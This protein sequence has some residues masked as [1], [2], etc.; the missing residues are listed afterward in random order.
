[1]A[2]ATQALT[3][4]GDGNPS[5]R[6]GRIGEILTEYVGEGALRQLGLI[7]GLAAS[8]AAGIGLYQWAQEPMYRSLFAGLP[9]EDA[10][11]VAESL[12]AAGI[13]HHI[14]QVSGAIQ[15][16][17]AMLHDAR[18]K[19]AAEGLPN[20]GGVGFESL[21]Q[22]PGF[23][24]SHF[25]ETARFHRAL[26]TELG[27]TIASLRAVQSARVHLAIP[28]RSAFLRDQREPRAS[29]TVSLYSGRSL[30]DGQVTAIANMVASAVPELAVANVT[31]VDQRGRLL[32]AAG[33]GSTASSAT[34]LDYQR[35]IEQ[36]YV[37]SIRDLL[38]PI[39]G[40]DS[41]R[42]EVN[43]RIDFSRT[44]QTQEL[45]DPDGAVLRSEQ[46]S[47]QASDRSNQAMGIPGALTNQPPGEGELAPADPLGEEALAEG[48]AG[49]EGG[50]P[51]APAIIDRSVSETR[52]YEISRTVR[53][54]TGSR[55]VVERLSVAVL[56]DEP[57]TVND[58]GET[59]PAPFTEAQLAQI[60]SLVRQAV[61]F[62]PARGDTL[63]VVSVPFQLEPQPAPAAPPVWQRPWLWEGGK[64]VLAALLGL[65]LILVVLRPL[66][67]GLLGRDRRAGQRRGAPAL[68][69]GTQ[70]AALA[71]PDG[72][73]QLTGPE[74]GTPAFAGRSVSYEDNLKAAREVAG[75]EPELAANVVRSW[76][77]QGGHE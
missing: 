21:R 19:L 58:N 76:L 5:P 38:V 66:V 10:A 49:A 23:G 24:T 67:N 35:R 70:A 17:A 18:L 2:Q 16:P 39:V 15:V 63:D 43:A 72:A 7:I 44:E 26:E 64:L 12:T 40:A 32:T 75:K 28:E 29:V 48:E 68:A 61:G 4:P 27:R 3:P 77:G 25:M 41:V 1:M 71:A 60:E 50:E 20:T 62:D 57:V 52:N 46:I 42:A 34:Q 36:A 11:A 51:P 69:Q 73:P 22:D 8:I 45:Y 14:D 33:D 59:V 65:V 47:E 6:Q 37:R 13:P 54:T 53:H 74:G 56:V 55:G 31:V 30:T 9:A